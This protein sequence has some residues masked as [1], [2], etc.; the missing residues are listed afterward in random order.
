M[1]QEEGLIGRIVGGM[2]RRSVRARF[3]N[4]YWRPPT[5][6]IQPPAILYANHHGWMD[7]YLMF[8]LVR[9]LNLVCLDWIEEFDTFPLFTWVGGV[10]FAKGD[11]SGRALAIRRTIRELQRGKS[12]VLFAEGFLHRPPQ[13]FPLGRSLEAL[14]KQVPNLSLVPVAIY[15]EMSMHERPEAW[16]SVGQPHE[17]VSLECSRERLQAELNRLRADVEAEVKFDVLAAGTASINERMS[18]KRFRP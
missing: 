6:S 1:S 12:L 14:A 10:R 3:R 18:M 17:F 7:G 9:K 15:Q 4:V 11:T 5:S 13:I 8:H 2:I 16:I